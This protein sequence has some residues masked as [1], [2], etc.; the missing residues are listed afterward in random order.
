[1]ITANLMKR[2]YRD[3]PH[4]KQGEWAAGYLAEKGV[5]PKDR[6]IKNSLPETGHGR[7]MSVTL[8]LVKLCLS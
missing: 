2:A 6:M 4:E 1:L 8:F 5:D 7:R 3:S